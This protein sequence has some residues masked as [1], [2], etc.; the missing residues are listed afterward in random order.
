MEKCKG[1]HYGLWLQNSLED[2]LKFLQADL[3]VTLSW[4]FFRTENFITWQA[5]DD[6]LFHTEKEIE[7]TKVN[8]ALFGPIWKRLQS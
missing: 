6:F 3:T 1:G 4:T 5:S 2:K 7:G 8:F